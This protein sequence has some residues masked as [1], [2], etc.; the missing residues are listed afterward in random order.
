MSFNQDQFLGEHELL[1]FVLNPLF[2]LASLFLPNL[3]L[4]LV[5]GVHLDLLSL[6]PIL[7][8]PTTR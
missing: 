5:E 3:L 4:L 2:E 1:T 6:A 8:E 7:I